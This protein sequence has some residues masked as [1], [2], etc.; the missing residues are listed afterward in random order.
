MKPR[1]WPILMT[2]R[3]GAT[4]TGQPGAAGE[5]RRTRLRRILEEQ[6]EARPRL[7]RAVAVLLG[8]TL[9]ALAAIGGLLLWH[10]RRRGRL[11]RERLSPPRIVRLPDFPGSEI[12]GPS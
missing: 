6:P 10:V 12:D 9:V 7:G 2:D 11:I 8:T 5:P 4:L 1:R 3:D